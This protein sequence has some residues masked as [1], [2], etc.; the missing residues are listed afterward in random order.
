MR[1]PPLFGILLVLT[2]VPVFISLGHWQWQK[3]ERKAQAQA[4]RDTRG[5]DVAVEMPTA[6][7]DPASDMATQLHFRPVTMRGHFLPARQFLVD[8][9][10]HRERVGFHVVTPFQ[11]DSGASKNPLVVLVD[12][13]WIPAGVSRSDTPVIHTPEGVITLRGIAVLPPNRFFSLSAVGMAPDWE[14][15]PLPVWQRLDRKAF[16]EITRL[17]TQGVIVQLDASSPAGFVREWPRPDERIE[18]HYS[19]A[20]Q[21]Y[22]FAAA[23]V[24][25]WLF[26]LFRRWRP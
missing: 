1:W 13:G 10:V 14:G 6:L 19:Y 23:T 9:R 15:A 3:G 26:L 22:G 5:A 2:L 4:L 8:N 12:R 16:A 20:L 18:R 25:I 24:G 17:P 7:F 11:I 21:W